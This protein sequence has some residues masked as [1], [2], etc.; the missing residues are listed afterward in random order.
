ML[1]LIFGQLALF[2]P[3]KRIKFLHVQTD[4]FVQTLDTVIQLVKRKIVV[5]GIDCLELAAIYGDIRFREEF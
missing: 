5:L 3:V 2:L 4:V 1:K